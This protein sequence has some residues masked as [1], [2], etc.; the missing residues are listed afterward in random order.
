MNA[1]EHKL[2][3]LISVLGAIAVVIVAAREPKPEKK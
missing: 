3:V 2:M 1:T